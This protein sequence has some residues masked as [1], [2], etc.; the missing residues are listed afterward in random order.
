MVVVVVGMGV[1]VG[2][3]VGAC[4]HV[5]AGFEGARGLRTSVQAAEEHVLQSTQE[6]LLGAAFGLQGAGANAGADG[7]ALD[8]GPGGGS[9]GRVEPASPTA[10]RSPAA[11]TRLPVATIPPCLQIYSACLLTG[12][13]WGL[14]VCSGRPIGTRVSTRG[15]MPGLC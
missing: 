12:Q 3:G 13:G 2:V 14:P 4:P 1:G 11:H 10:Y 15:S 6:W 9:G 7:S 5:V 8:A